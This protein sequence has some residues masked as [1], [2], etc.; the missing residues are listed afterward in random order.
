MSPAERVSLA[1]FLLGIA[2]GF[3][4]VAFIA[5]CEQAG[6]ESDADEDPPTT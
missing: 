3:G 2:A 6:R 1:L 4:I 5:W